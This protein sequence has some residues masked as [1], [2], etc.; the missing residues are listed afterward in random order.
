MI[1]KSDIPRF[2]FDLGAA[3]KSLEKNQT[4]WTPGISIIVAMNRALDMLLE[5]GMENAIRRHESLA[6][7]AWAGAEALG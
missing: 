3:K 5:E 4:P 6:K 7:A 2:Y 1:E